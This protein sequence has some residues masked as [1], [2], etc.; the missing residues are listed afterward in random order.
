MILYQAI[1]HEIRQGI[2]NNTQILLIDLF[3]STTFANFYVI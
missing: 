2:S 1:S 3:K